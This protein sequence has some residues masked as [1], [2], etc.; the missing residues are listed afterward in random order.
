MFSSSYALRERMIVQLLVVGVI[1]VVVAVAIV[2][3]NF[4]F[5]LNCMRMDSFIFHN[6]CNGVDL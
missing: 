4:K 3:Q 1:F 2:V 5:S 6:C